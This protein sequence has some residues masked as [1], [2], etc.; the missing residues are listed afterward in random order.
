MLNYRRL[1]TV[2]TLAAVLG[3]GG[4]AWAATTTFNLTLRGLNAAP[5]GDRHDSAKAVVTI[6]SSRRR[7]CWTFTALNGIGPPTRANIG[8]APRGKNGPIVVTLGKPFKPKGCSTASARTLTGIL[9]R[10]TS[11]YIVLTN[12]F[13]PNG[14]V[15]AQL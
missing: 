2:L 7:I 4:I 15:R 14:A 13:H 8:K 10:P 3:T 6:E 12:P 1:A 11:Y 9:K 5:R